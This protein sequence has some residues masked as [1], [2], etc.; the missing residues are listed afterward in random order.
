[1]EKKGNKNITDISSNIH[2]LIMRIMYFHKETFIHNGKK[3]IDESKPKAIG[4]QC[5]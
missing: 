5:Q 4:L 2:R 1:M 3:I